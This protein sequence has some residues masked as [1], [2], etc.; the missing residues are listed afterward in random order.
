[1]DYC[2]QLHGESNPHECD[3]AV[4]WVPY[5]VDDHNGNMCGM[6]GNFNTVSMF[7]PT[8]IVDEN[9]MYM[10]FD[11]ATYLNNSY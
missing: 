1:S 6:P 2:I 3:G 5:V 9:P 4:R 11:A 7:S 8:L 10:S